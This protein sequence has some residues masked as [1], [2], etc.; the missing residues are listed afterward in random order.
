LG[1]LKASDD[2]ISDKRRLMSNND[3]INPQLADAQPDDMFP[4]LTTDKQSRVA[5]H[6]RLRQ[7]EKGETVVEANAESKKFFVVITGQLNLLRVSQ[8]LERL[9]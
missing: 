5:A 8:N 7:V 1:R 9:A 4:V 3:Q 2:L 6:G